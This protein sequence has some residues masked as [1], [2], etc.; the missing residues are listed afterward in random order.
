MTFLF[1]LCLS[2]FAFGQEKYAVL[3][4]G[5]YASDGIPIEHQWNNGVGKT[6]EGVVEFWNDTYLMWEM[7]QEK[8]YSPDNIFVL[9]ADGQDFQPGWI[10]NEYKPPLGVTI[11]DYSASIANVQSV[12][13]GLAAGTG[14]FPQVT[15]DDFLFV[16]TFDHGW[17]YN[18]N[19][20]IY[21]IDGGMTDDEF[22]A[23]VNPITAHK[24]V[25]WM[26]QCNGGGFED[27][28]EANNTVFISASGG[29]QLAY[30]AD[31]DWD[32]ENEVI[33]NIVY[34]HSEF[35]FHMHSSTVGMDPEGHTVYGNEAAIEK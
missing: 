34:S 23:L 8:G 1:T 17:G 26:L 9:F 28:L 14:G 2:I 3:I 4:T 18:G 5:D 24:K 35:N 12:F 21:L 20:G 25:F 22:G 15:E 11:T 16:W 30:R 33:N 19:S 6:T 13:N 32:V 7:L 31:N 10:A 27:E 29:N